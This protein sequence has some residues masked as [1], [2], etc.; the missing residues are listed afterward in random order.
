MHNA[1]KWSKILKSF[2]VKFLLKFFGHFS[3][4]SARWVKLKNYETSNHGRLQQSWTKDSKQ[5]D[6]VK[7]NSFFHGMFYS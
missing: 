1:E 2:G 7:Q 6:E 3:S 5:I 4:V